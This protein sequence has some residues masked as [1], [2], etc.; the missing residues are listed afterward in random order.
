MAT[1]LMKGPYAAM[2]RYSPMAV[3][4]ALLCGPEVAEPTPMGGRQ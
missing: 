1:P 2:R 4:L 3:R